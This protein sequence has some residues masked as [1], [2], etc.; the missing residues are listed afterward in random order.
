MRSYHRCHWLVMGMILG[1]CIPR[2][3]DAQSPTPTDSLVGRI[4]TLAREANPR[5]RAFRSALA[6]A[7]GELRAA[8]TIAAPA[9]EAEVEGIPDGIDVSNA[10]QMRLMLDG[11]LLR[12]ARRSAQ[13]GIARA[14]RDQA[15]VVL[16]LAERGLLARVRRDLS[17]WI[18]WRTVAARLVEE[19]SLLQSAEEG[20]R[21][22]FAVGEARYIDVLRL[23]TE[24]LLVRAEGGEALRTSQ[25]GRTRLDGLVLPGDQAATALR[26]L[27]EGVGSAKL[28][29]PFETALPPPDVDSLTAALGAL[30]SGDFGV[31]EARARADLLRATLRPQLGA[32][33]GLQRFGDP[34]NGFDTGPSL[35]AGITLPFL[36]G[37]FVR[38]QREAAELSVTSAESD[39]AA[40]AG[41]LR[42]A[43]HLVH[44]RYVA[45]L[46]RLEVYDVALLAG[47]REERE[48]ALG[49]YRSG[50]LSLIELLDLERALARAET[51]RLRA[52]I[53][54]DDAYARFFTTIAALALPSVRA[55]D[56]EDGND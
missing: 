32:G 37:G 8:G 5:L 16:E 31:Q 46:R 47:A 10:G 53:D 51:E 56:L 1:T 23:R 3:I 44:D 42:T 2:S 30:R 33:V 13:R 4:L 52:A 43:L 27:L 20:L 26:Q 39:R 48:G 35:R 9:L 14:R 25:E 15:A 17:A 54:A 40:V 6:V 38:R 50:Q 28:R 11:E 12:G 49:A 19:D 41:E 45:A 29:F 24:R 55:S 21:A 34:V 18:G 36:T 22:R 7:E